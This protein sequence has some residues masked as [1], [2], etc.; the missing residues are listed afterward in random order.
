MSA[1]RKLVLSAAVAAL[2]AVLTLIFAPI[3]YGPVQFRIAEALTLLPFLFPPAVP[4]LFVGCLTANIF[5]SMGLI[6][7][8]AGSLTTLVAAVITSRAPNRW[9]GAIPPVVLNAVVIGAVITYAYI[10]ADGAFPLVLNMLLVGAGQGVVCL[11]I[12]VPLI[13]LLGRSKA[14]QP[15]MRED[16]ARLQKKP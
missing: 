14:L 1:A 10:G 2:Y 11:G 6:D 13:T 7:I 5:S 15:F 8:V 12:G 16:R 9:L 4:G 3:S